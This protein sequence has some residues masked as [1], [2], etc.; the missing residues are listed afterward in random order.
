MECMEEL[1]ENPEKAII[2][3][4][5]GMSSRIWIKFVLS[6]PFPPTL[7]SPNLRSTHPETL[8]WTQIDRAPEEP[9]YHW[10]Q[11]WEKELL[12]LKG[13]EEISPQLFSFCFYS[14]VLQSPGH[15][16]LVA[17]ALTG[18]SKNK[19][20]EKEHFLFY[21]ATVSRGWNKPYCCVLFCHS[22]L[23]PFEPGHES[24]HKSPQQHSTVGLLQPRFLAREPKRVWAENGKV[25]GRF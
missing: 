1:F 25:P 5:S 3:G 14:L 23:L 15:L 6:L 11:D 12:M 24:N 7:P 19:N 9:L 2:V 8:K 16:V 18:T 20:T 17:G 21:G 10:L 13:N 4:R 22:V